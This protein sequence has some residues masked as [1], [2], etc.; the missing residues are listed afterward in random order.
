VEPRAFLISASCCG[1]AFLITHDYGDLQ[2]TIFFKS[3]IC[4]E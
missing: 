1:H 4:P 2:L 3:A